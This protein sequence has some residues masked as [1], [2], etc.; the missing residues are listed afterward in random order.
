MQHQ[1]SFAVQTRYI[2]LALLEPQLWHKPFQA[3]AY[4]KVRVCG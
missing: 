3:A 2:D 4:R 1:A